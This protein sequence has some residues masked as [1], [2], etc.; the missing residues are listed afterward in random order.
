MQK[1]INALA[2][3]AG[4]A[5]IALAIYYWSTPADALPHFL[6][7][8]I[9]TQTTPHFKHGVGSFIVGLG[10]LAYVWFATGK[11]KRLGKH[12]EAN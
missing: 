9:A 3:I 5:L 6:P 4:L 10:L 7:G 2:V 1:L 11:K 12:G 8:Y